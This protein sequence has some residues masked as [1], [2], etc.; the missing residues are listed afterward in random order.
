MIQL[1]RLNNRARLLLILA[2]A[3]VAGIKLSA[4]CI[5]DTANCEDIG[6]PGQ[7]C[8]LLLPKAGLNILYDEVVTI[9]APGA[10][11]IGGTELTI[12][13]IEIDSVKNLPPGI[14]YFPNA[15]I[16]YPDTAYCIQLTGTP[17]QTGEFAL[18]IYITATVDVFGTPTRAQVVDDSSVVISVVEVL[19]ID[20]N[21][22]T[23]FQ[24]S[25]N[26]PNPFSDRTR[27]SFYTPKQEKV[28]L[29]IYNILG[30]LVHQETELT[31]PGKHYFNFDGSELEAG[32]YLYRIESGEDFFTGKLMKSR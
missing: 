14:D 29:S 6:D 4:Q 8:P 28:E 10:Y 26:V 17:S 27:L 11:P 9:I 21:Q 23:G 5:P 18:S 16:F 13:Y 12:H 3:I 1:H 2:L 31:A 7:F 20:P 24:V 25:Q 22:K 19:G 30:V 15:D 32:T